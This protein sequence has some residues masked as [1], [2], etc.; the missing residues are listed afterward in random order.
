EELPGPA[1]A[2]PYATALSALNGSAA[3]GTWRLYVVS[4]MGV[5]APPSPLDTIGGWSLDITADRPPA[6]EDTGP[7]T[8][9]H[10]TALTIALVCSDPD[11]DALTYEIIDAPAD[12]T[13]SS[14]GADGT[15]TY[16]PAPGF[17]GADT[18]TYRAADADRHSDPA[19]ATI[20]VAAAPPAPEPPAPAPPAS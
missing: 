15:V 20:T 17:S 11:A 13:L 9:A 1:P 19:T 7:H 14:V 4:T 2:P 6:C 12:G 8:T 16:T 10:G 18:F 3:N 5:G